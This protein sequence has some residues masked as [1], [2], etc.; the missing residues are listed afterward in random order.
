MEIKRLESEAPLYSI[1]LR[2]V[3]L[4][5]FFRVIAHDY[6]LNIIVDPAVRGTVTAS[7]TSIALEEAL[8]GIAELSNLIIQKKGNIFRVSPHLVTETFVLKY[9]EAKKI[10]Q[11]AAAVPGAGTAAAPA[12]TGTPAAPAGTGTPAAGGVSGASSAQESTIFDLLS[13]QGRLFLGEKPN[14]VIVSDYPTNVKKIGEY[15]NMVDQKMTSR[16]FKLKYLKATDVVGQPAAA[17][18]T[19]A[20]ATAATAAAGSSG[21]GQ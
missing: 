20:A 2:N 18:G 9:T 7:F 15:L 4:I 5:D 6:D 12:G 16:V 19:T 13:E 21:G 10:L 8:D 1:E 3:Q 14:S 17:T 11:G